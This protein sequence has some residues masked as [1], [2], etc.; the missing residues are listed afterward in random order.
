MQ[1]VLTKISGEAKF[2][3][4]IFL[5]LALIPLVFSGYILFILPLNTCCLA[6]LQYPYLFYG[7][8]LV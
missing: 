2:E 8:L 5:A 6:C 1:N 7:G 3:L 4:L